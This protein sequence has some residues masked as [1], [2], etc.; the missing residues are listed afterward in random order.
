MHAAPHEPCRHLSDVR[1]IILGD[2]RD[3]VSIL[4]STPE[5]VDLVP[6][7]YSNIV[8]ALKDAKGVADVAGIPGRLVKIR[9]K[10]NAFMDPEF[11]V[12]DHLAKLLLVVMK[13]S[14]KI[15]SV[16]NLT[17]NDAV[18][19]TIRKL[20][21]RYDMLERDP[22]YRDKEDRLA[23]FAEAAVKNSEGWLDV[24]IDAG[25]FGIEPNAYIFDESATKLAD[26]IVRIAKISSNSMR[27]NP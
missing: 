9:G 2:L 23:Q 21:L 10:V 3:A 6:E 11:G 17:Y 7:V 5:F 14:P 18:L 16:I 1:R 22:T 13:I 15:R 27:S 19:D 24:V 26:R 25:G 4:E 12:S 8:M 20:G